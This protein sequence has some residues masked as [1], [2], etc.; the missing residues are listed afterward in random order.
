MA[1]TV[2]L[3]ADPWSGYAKIP[4]HVKVARQMDGSKAGDVIS[5]IKVRGEPNAVHVSK[6]TIADV[7]VPAY[8]EFLAN[9]LSQIFDCIG[10]RWED[11]T[12][13][14]NQTNLFGEIIVRAPS[15]KLVRKKVKTKK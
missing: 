13:K 11:V 2:G 9:T 6:A 8:E 5:Y 14:Q 1:F 7:N 3:Q 4:M 10:M 15:G 12:Y